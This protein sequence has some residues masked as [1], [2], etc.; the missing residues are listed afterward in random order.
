M[1]N[2]KSCVLTVAFCVL[3]SACA[4]NT[5]NQ[6]TSA[7]VGQQVEVEFGK[8]VAIRHVKIQH[9]DTGVGAGAGMLAGAGA[10]SAIGNGNGNGIAILGGMVIGGIAGAV[11]EH[12][13]QNL[14]GIAY[15]ITKRNGKTVVITQN[16][17]KDDEP[18]S[19]GQSVMI[20]TSGIYQ[21]V[22]PAEDL[23]EKIKKPKDIKVEE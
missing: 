7:E 16:I 19:K 1:K 23:P 6:F 5:Q 20:E 8:I 22:L 12:K 15:T 3:L 13:L 11:A 17:G 9:K 10:G 4:A 21:R 18:L 14:R 2:I